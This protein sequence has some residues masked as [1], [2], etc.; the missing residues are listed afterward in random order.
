M[1][2]PELV[3][4]GTRMLYGGTATT[5]LDSV[6]SN[7]LLAPGG[8]GT[9]ST[10]YG[11]GVTDPNGRT[12]SL[13]LNWMSHPTGETDPNGGNISTSYSKQGFPAAVTDALGR[14]TSYTYLCS[15][16]PQFARNFAAALAWVATVRWP[17]LA[18]AA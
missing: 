6:Q 12:T 16:Q 15:G 9:L 3:V 13:T 1:V 4:P 7:G 18:L 17:R 5:T 2:S 8:Q 11:A 14:T 10:T